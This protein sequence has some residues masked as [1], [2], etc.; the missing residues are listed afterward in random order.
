MLVLEL[1]ELV[2]LAEAVLTVNL[3]F[4]VQRLLPKVVACRE[5]MI[6]QWVGSRLMPASAPQDS[7]P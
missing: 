7:A 1:D 3:D 5:R 6:A 2:P 4:F